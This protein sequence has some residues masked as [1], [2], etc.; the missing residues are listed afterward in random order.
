MAAVRHLAAHD[1]DVRVV[2]SHRLGAAAWSRHAARAYS[3]PPENESQRFIERLL[4]IGA[5]DPGQILLP[6]SDETAWL[7]M[8]NADLL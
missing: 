2:S 7:Y 1:I 3:A 4:A 6:T 5:A 8:E